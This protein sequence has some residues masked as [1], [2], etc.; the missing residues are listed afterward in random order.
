[1]ALTEV[2][3]APAKAMAPQSFFLIAS[4]PLILLTLIADIHE[5][6]GAEAPCWATAQPTKQ[7]PV[8]WAVAQ[9]ALLHAFA[10]L[11]RMMV[12]T[13]P[14]WNSAGKLKASSAF[15]RA[16]R[17]VTMVSTSTRPVE[18]SLMARS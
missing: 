8:G 16:N 2:M 14:S 17:W 11:G 12:L 1:M 5:T 9:Q 4:P 10:W 18:T 7:E 6:A 13:A 3:S 15:S